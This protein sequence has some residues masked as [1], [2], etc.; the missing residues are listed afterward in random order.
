MFESPGKVLKLMFGNT[1]RFFSCDSKS[2]AFL[3]EYKRTWRKHTGQLII[4]LHFVIETLIREMFFENR[5][6]HAQ[7]L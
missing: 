4:F 6:K 7:F 5:T 1:G 3:E 2:T